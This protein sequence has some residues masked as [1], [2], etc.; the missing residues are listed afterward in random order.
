MTL[1]YVWV[2]TFQRQ[3]LAYSLLNQL[4]VAIIMGIVALTGDLILDR[5]SPPPLTMQTALQVSMAT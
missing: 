5:R 1:G 4:S 2:D 3:A